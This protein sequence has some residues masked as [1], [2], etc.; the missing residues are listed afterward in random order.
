MATKTIGSAVGRDFATLTL[1]SAYLNVLVLAAPEIGQM[2]ADS[3]FSQ[4]IGVTI[5]GYTGASS[6][7]TVTLNCGPAQSFRDN[8][9]VQT[10]ALRYNAANGVAVKWTTTYIL[11]LTVSGTFFTA[12][13]LQMTGTGTNTEG[14]VRNTGTDNTVN[15]CILQFKP[16]L[17]T[18][19]QAALFN[20]ALRFTAENISLYVANAIGRAV[21]DSASTTTGLYVDITIIGLSSTATGFTFAYTGSPVKNCPVY[22]F[23]TDYSGT[24]NGASTNNATD[25]GAFGGTNFGTSGQV[26]ITSAEWQSLTSG[27]EDFRLSPSSTKLKDNGATT[28][29]TT[30]IAKTTR[31]APYDIGCWELVAAASSGFFFRNPSLS[32]LGSGGPF[33]N[34]PLG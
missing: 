2:Y 15:N 27:S 3:E 5:G 23:T 6:T 21:Q 13:G 19:N 9:N 34:N 1:W 25:K 8:A 28:G 24:A 16:R 30:D 4:A 32:G 12:D 22:G 18:V 11:P 17:G 7:N 31:V 29:P 14:G 20:N 33:F 26:S 10:N